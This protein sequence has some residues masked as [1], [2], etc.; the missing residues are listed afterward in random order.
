MAEVTNENDLAT[1]IQGKV[2]AYVEQLWEKGQPLIL[3]INGS[4]ELVVQ[5]AGSYQR[6]VELVDWVE[7]IEGIRQGLESFARGEGR[8]A[9]EAHEQIRR[10]FN[11]P[12]SA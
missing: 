1:N 3:S 9:H 4:A 8:P 11:L 7:A 10:T 6:L 2:A 5:D 12:Q